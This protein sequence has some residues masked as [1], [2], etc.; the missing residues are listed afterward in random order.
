MLIKRSVIFTLIAAILLSCAAP[1]HIVNPQQMNFS[2]YK[3]GTG[4]DFAMRGNVLSDAGNVRYANKE[5]KTGLRVVAVEIENKTDKPIVLRENAKF[6]SG[7]KNIYPVEAEQISHQ[8]KQPAG[9]YMLWSLLWV[10]ISKCDNTDCSV[11]PLPVGFFIGLGN[12]SKAKKSNK[13][14]LDELNANNILDK[15]IM[16]GEKARGLLGFG[17][18]NI[19][20]IRIE[21]N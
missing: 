17:E 2:N 12:M 5:M 3:S 11:V 4:V 8:L 14:L 10:V 21:I 1:Y 16:P 9:L 19:D 13:A 20:A 15:K 7:T 6:Y 18:Q